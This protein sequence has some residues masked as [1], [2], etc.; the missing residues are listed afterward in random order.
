[1]I[2]ISGKTLGRKKPLF[3]DWSIPFPPDLKNEGD[4]VTLR[5][6]IAR[7]VRAEVE[8][9]RTRQEERRLVK[10]L[11]RADIDQGAAKGRI[12]MGGRELKQAVDEEDAVGTALQAFEDGLYLVIVDGEEQ[13]DLDREV[14][15]QP[16][17]RVTFVRLAMLAGG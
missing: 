17:S 4:R 9:F 10:A 14:F 5:D 13:R 1:M 2:T 11:S 6:L 7:V 15:V 16:D 8:A 12:D 3:A